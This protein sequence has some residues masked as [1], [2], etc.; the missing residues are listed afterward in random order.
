MSRT[1]LSCVLILVCFL[2]LSADPQT[3]IAGQIADSEGAAIA[4]A[5]VL[6]HWDSSGS[7]VGL[8]D[9]I[10]TKQ[11]MIVVTDPSGNYSVGVPAGFYDVFVSAMVFTPTATKVRVKQSQRT[12]FNAKLQADPPCFEGTGSCRAEPALTVA[13]SR[14]HQFTLGQPFCL[15]VV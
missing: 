6:I 3:A 2:S 15:R 4:G 8:T 9:N 5:R 11:D 7:T 1:I 13:E 10:G 14:L 12:T